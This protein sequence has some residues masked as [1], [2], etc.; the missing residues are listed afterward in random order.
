LQVVR[1]GKERTVSVE[2]AKLPDQV[3]A[4][5]EPRRGGNQKEDGLAQPQLGLTLAPA[6]SVAGAGNEGVVITEVEPNGP[7]AERGMQSGDVI[8]EVGGKKVSSPADVRDAVNTARKENKANVL[9]RMKRENN[10]RFVTLPV[11]KG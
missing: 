9:V 2:L 4:A 8:L 7:A 3:A 1:D 10:S 11:A 5:N 6:A